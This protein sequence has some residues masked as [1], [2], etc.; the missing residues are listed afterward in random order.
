M[1]YYYIEMKK[2]EVRKERLLLKD[3]AKTL[4]NEI[5]SSLNKRTAFDYQHDIANT[6][7]RSSLNKLIKTFETV[8][9][10][11]MNL[12]K[13]ITKQSI[14]EIKK[15][16]REYNEK[17]N[18]A[19]K[20]K[21]RDR[22]KYERTA[23]GGTFKTSTIYADDIGNLEKV[24]VDS[25][26]SKEYEPNYEEYEKVLVNRLL[27]EYKS[28]NSLKDAKYSMK[29]YITT[30][31]LLYKE[32][33]TYLKNGKEIQYEYMDLDERIDPKGS[34]Y[35][36]IIKSTFL[37]FVSNSE[38]DVIVS[39]NNIKNFVLGVIKKFENDMEN[40]RGSE[41]RFRKFVKFVIKTQK[42]KS[43]FGKSYI[44]LPQLL[45][46]KK[47]CVNIKNDDNRC[48][49]WCL[50]ASKV[51]D[52]I[53]SKDKNELYHYKKNQD[54]IKIPDDIEYPIR[55]DDIHKYEELNDIQINVFSLDEYDD[56]TKNIKDCIR[57]EYKANKHRKEV[58]NLLLIEEDG[59]THYVLIN[60]LSRLFACKTTKRVKYFCDNCL[61]KS[62]MTMDLLEKHKNKCCNL[63]EFEKKSLDVSC[64][65]PE[66]GS[67]KSTL[68]FRNE[69]N[70]FKHPFHVIADFE[71]TLSNCKSDYDG[72]TK[73]EYDS[74]KTHRYQ[75]HLQN[76]FGVKYCCI[77]DEYSKDVKIMNNSDPDVVSKSFVETL[78]DYAKDSYK[79]LQKNKTNIRWRLKDKEEHK[80]SNNCFDCKKKYT[81][82]NK[83]VAHHDHISGEFIS[84]LC[85]ECNLK[86][87]YKAF[88]PVYIHNLKGYDAHLF[89]VALNKY[90]YQD[91]D[92]TCIP[93]NEERYISFSKK[94]KVD[95][96]FCKKEN[97]L[98]PILFEIRFLDTIAFMATSIEKLVDNLSSG[99]DDIIKLRK[100]FPN[101]SKQFKDDEQFQMMTMKGIYPYDFIDTYDKL[102]ISYLPEKKYFY[103]H[104]YNS[105]C[106]DEDYDQALKVWDKFNCKTF[107]D[108]HNLYL[109]SD[110]NLLADVWNSFRNTCYQNYE[111][112]TSYYFTA[113]GLSWDAML[114]HTKIELELFTDV[115]MYE[116]QEAGIR[117]GLSQIS[118]RHAV[119]NNKYMSNYDKT[120]EDSY[121]LYLDANNLYGW[122][123]SSYLPYKNFSWNNDE[124]DQE[125]IMSID[126]KADIGYT[127]EVDLHIPDELHDYFN[128]YVPCPSNVQVQ[129]KDL[130]E[131]QQEGY[132]ESKVRKLCTS[133]HDKI[134]YVVSYRYLKLVLSL[135]VQLVKV[136]RVMQYT[137]TDFLKTYIQLNTNLRTKATNDFEKDFFKLMNNSVFGKTMENVRSRINFRLVNNENAA[138]RVK[139]LNRFTIF[140]DNLVGVHIQKK[141]IVLNK[142]IYLGPAVLDDSKLLMYDFHYNFMLKKVE[143]KNIDLLFTD[144]DSLCYNIKKI[145]IFQVMKENKEYFDLSEYP[146]DH[147]LYDPTNKK[148][149]GKFKNESIEQITEFVGLRSKLY[150]YSV[151]LSSKKHLKCK[152]VKSCVVKQELNIERYRNTLYSR[153]SQNVNQNTIRSYNHQLYTETINKIALSCRDD[154]LY[155]CDDNVHTYNYGHYKIRN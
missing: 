102:N 56:D 113:P 1:L 78:E 7:H 93:N 21:V 111:L 127:F 146:K 11:N 86:Y 47:C 71:S 133:F 54:K 9:E 112:D 94:I 69:K 36:M 22:K 45:I 23:L 123:M 80:K 41:W 61:V 139:N 77:H 88:L 126:D 38:I 25:F 35:E 109:L 53:K 104:L 134:D 42:L 28:I 155:I 95:E 8:K 147:E 124:W 60:S 65:C 30:E 31:A 114:K 70:K 138:W 14:K 106:S 150:A 96:F 34:G 18:K 13:K 84:S 153:K 16:K 6:V 121:I 43:V 74:L 145:D 140:D 97:K 101:T 40:T 144:T 131:W 151:D 129:K 57:E 62:F 63:D 73:E 143:R 52:T 33:I 149:I 99:C 81:V 89:V 37:E 67:D 44:K 10:A 154:K 141:K 117:G 48:F 46:N 75:K 119:A 58:V 20:E 64:E 3:K 2:S 5:K 15:E 72:L 24:I 51:Y 125:K 116:F 12:T 118:T 152:G 120:K 108:Y 50:I 132:K 105:D 85:N 136:K 49:D 128:N 135:G 130:N 148:V 137:Q 107:L 92:I 122:A 29:T 26:G 98:R 17:L 110:V 66:E 83:K 115:D 79:L 100:A 87:Q 68:K 90:G 4:F 142:P 39:E 82:E 19:T 27:S 103:S 91:A 32:D 55:L 59:K 76:S